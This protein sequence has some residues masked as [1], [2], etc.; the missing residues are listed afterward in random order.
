MEW[1]ESR[2]Q[3]TIRKISGE[4]ALY[5]QQLTVKFQLNLGL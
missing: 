1:E 2:D 4:A 5:Q 3:S